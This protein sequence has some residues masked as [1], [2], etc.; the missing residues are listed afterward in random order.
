MHGRRVEGRQGRW[1]AKK[2]T[3]AQW[4]TGKEGGE[5]E[6]AEKISNTGRRSQLVSCTRCAV[7]ASE[8]WMR[9]ALLFSGMNLS[10]LSGY[11]VT[12]TRARR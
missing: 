9:D 3:S 1:E 10:R 2:T 6:Y 12:R 4:E 7:K 11:T 8:D 5:E